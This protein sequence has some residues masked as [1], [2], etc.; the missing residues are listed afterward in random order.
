MADKPKRFPMKG[1]GRYFVLGAAL[2]A[3][4]V[5]GMSILGGLLQT[6][7]QPYH[8]LFFAVEYSGGG[9]GDYRVSFALLNDEMA[10]GPSNGYVTLRVLDA[11]NS[12]VY[13]NTFVLRASNFST[14]MDPQH[15][16][17][18]IGYSFVVHL[19]NYTAGASAN[20]S[21]LL[22]QMTYLSMAGRSV[23]A[24]TTVLR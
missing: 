22:F 8:F 18:A 2:V 19:A 7:I 11:D 1:E 23:S 5:L 16:G 24:T 21:V 3:S 12:T 4:L 20:M 14:I 13:L 6:E 17:E 9:G 10:N 15:G